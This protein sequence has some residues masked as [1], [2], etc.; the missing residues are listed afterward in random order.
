MVT[1]QPRQ[2]PD[3]HVCQWGW[4]VSFLRADTAKLGALDVRGPRTGP[5][6]G[7]YDGLVSPTAGKTA[8]TIVA[9]WE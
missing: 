4:F 2:H 8:K 1:H 6:S 7:P 9:N 5:R 3:V